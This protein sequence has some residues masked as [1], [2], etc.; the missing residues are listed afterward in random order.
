MEQR[1]LRLDRR[2]RFDEDERAA[3][4]VMDG[5]ACGMVDG[6]SR[7][8]RRTTLRLA[9]QVRPSPVLRGAEDDQLEAAVRRRARRRAGAGQQ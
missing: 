6:A 3:L 5:N 8:S 4:S 1:D 2:R 9:T 7:A